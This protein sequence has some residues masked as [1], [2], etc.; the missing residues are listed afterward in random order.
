MIG[1]SVT[2]DLGRYHATPWGAHVNEATIEWPP[3]PWRVL[4]AIYAA[5]LQTV[6][7]AES[8]S[9]LESAL[10]RLATAPPPYFQLPASNEAHTRHYVP[11][12]G[13]SPSKPGETSL[14]VDAFRVLDP[15]N[16]LRVWWDVDLDVVER[17]ALNAA[18]GAIGYLGRSESVCTV[19][20]FDIRPDGEADAIPVAGYPVGEL[21]HDAS[22]VDL[23]AVSGDTADPVAVLGLSVTDLRKRRTLQ[24]AGTTR[25]GYLVRRPAKAAPNGVCGPVDRP[26]IALLR[27]V[28]GSR[29]GLT[30]ALTVGHVLRAALQRRFDRDRDGTR[31]PVFSGRDGDGPR[32][33]QH[34]HSHYL[35]FSGSD[36]RRIDHLVIWAPEGFGRPEVAALAELVDLRM[37][38]RPEPSRLALVAL[39]EPEQLK[40]RRALGPAE[41]WRSLTPMALPR[42]AKRRGGIVVD[43]PVD[44]I[45][46]ELGLRGFPQPLE[47]ELIRG[48]WMDFKRTRPGV[49]AREAAQVVGARIVFAEAVR[50]PIAIG[51]SSHF[52]LGVFEPDD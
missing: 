5:G 31:S 39:G 38:D 1:L 50:G 45:R 11:L 48:P 47:I 36:Q 22:R 18:V 12:A 15:T 30:E 4:R 37:R 41:C 8:R 24:P 20:T 49:S 34:A 9:G 43:G 42:H 3:S 44:Q 40:F 51:A 10:R 35:A 32:R 29:P 46:R 21:W 52:G 26:T 19:H 17:S 16:P 2:F 6:G 27:I 28:G 14:L 13:H 7:L 33:D 23:L 25:V